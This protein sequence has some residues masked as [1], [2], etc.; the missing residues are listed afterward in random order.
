MEPVW[1]ACADLDL[2]VVITALCRTAL[3]PGYLDLGERFLAARRSP[4]GRDAR[5][6]IVYRS[7]Y[8]GALQNITVG[9][10]ESGCVWLP[11][12]ASA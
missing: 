6:S 8:H 1:Q 12:G 9:I 3:F 11:S 7:R 2:A 4:L 5:R 10:L